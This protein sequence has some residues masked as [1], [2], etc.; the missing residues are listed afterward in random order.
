MVLTNGNLTFPT[1]TLT[2]SSA[3][4]G[5][6]GLSSGGKTGFLEEGDLRGRTPAFTEGTVRMN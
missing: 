1:F 4:H 6:M 3:A 5:F 2:R